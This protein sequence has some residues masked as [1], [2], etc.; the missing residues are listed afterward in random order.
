MPDNEDNVRAMWS[1]DELDQALS[2]LNADVSPDERAFGRA[3]T[4]LL[5]SAGGRVEDTPAPRR[6]RGWWFAAAGTV[7][8]ITASVVVVQLNQT[9]STAAGEQLVIAAD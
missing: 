3:R 7:V 5:M 9:V 4:E 2:T 6:R 1:E 8:A